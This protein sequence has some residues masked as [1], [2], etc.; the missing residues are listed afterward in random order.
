MT[1]S[2]TGDVQGID[3]S[4]STVSL[5]DFQRNK[6]KTLFFLFTNIEFQSQELVLVPELLFV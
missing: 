1:G 4:L 5:F 6:I 3:H 2:H